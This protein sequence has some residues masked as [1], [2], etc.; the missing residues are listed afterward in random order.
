MMRNWGEI[1]RYAQ[2]DRRGKRKKQTPRCARNDNAMARW[3][4]EKR[5]GRRGVGIEDVPRVERR[6][7]SLKKMQNLLAK[8]S[9]TQKAPSRESSQ[10]EKVQS[11]WV[12]GRAG[13][14]G[15]YSG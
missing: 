6:V 3:V 9:E 14:C 12:R 2:D 4:G 10:A 1:L 15:R 7:A 8:P 5:C 13:R 11:G